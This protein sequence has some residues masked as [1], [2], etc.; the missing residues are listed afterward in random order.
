MKIE[1]TLL[2][3]SL[4]IQSVLAIGQVPFIRNHELPAQWGE[5]KVDFIHQSPRGY[6]WLAGERGVLRFNGLTYEV[7]ETEKVVGSVRPSAILESS[8]QELWIGFEDGKL[9]ILTEEDSLVLWE[10]EEGWPQ[11]SISDLSEDRH[12]N[13]WIATN[14]E[15]LYAWD[16]K[17]LSNFDE[18][19]G[20]GS[21]EVAKLTLDRSNRV[22]AATDAG[23]SICWFEGKRKKVQQLG[24]THGLPDEIIVA[25]KCDSSGMCVAATYETGIVQI[26][27]KTLEV[28]PLSPEWHGGII[29]ALE[30][31]SP[32]QVA[33]GTDNRG[34]WRYD[35]SRSSLRPL[36]SDQLDGEKV[37]GLLQDE[38]GV[39]WILSKRSG[40]HSI[41]RHFEY[42][43]FGVDNIQALVGREQLWIGTREGLYRWMPDSTG[44]GS[45]QQVITDNILSLYE[46]ALGRIWAGGFGNGLYVINPTTLNYTHLDEATGLP[47]GSIISIDGDTSSVWVATLGGVVQFDL[48]T[49]PSGNP[50]PLQSLNHESGLETNFVYKVFVDSRGM[51]WLGTDGKGI[52]SWQ[53]GKW[54]RYQEAAGHSVKTVY[55]ITEDHY[56]NIWFNTKEHGIFKYDGQAFSYLG[57]EEGVKNHSI[58]GIATDNFGNILIFH[59]GG[60][61]HF[62]PISHHFIYFGKEVGVDKIDPS[63]NSYCKDK[64]GRHWIGTGKGAI[65]YTPLTDQTSI[66]PI[67][68]IEGIRA[69]LEPL[70]PKDFSS[71]PYH[72]NDLVFDYV[73]LWYSNPGA[74]TYKYKLEGYNKDWVYSRDQQ[75]TYPNVPPGTYT[76][77]VS[78]TEN[79]AFQDEPILSYAFEIRA[80][81]W[82][83]G[84]FLI[85]AALMILSL[86]YLLMKLRDRRIQREATLVKE[87]LVSQFETL[88]SQINPHFLFNTL[89]TLITV[90]DEDQQVA[91]EYV[92]KLADFYRSIL[93]YR[94]LELIPIDEELKIMKDY[95][96]I[97][98]KRFGEN[99]VVAIEEIDQGA[100]II[101]LTLQIL[102]E[103][104]VKHNVISMNQPLKIDI[105]QEEESYIC[106]RN[107]LQ[108]KL[109]PEPS[110]GFGLESICRRYDV[111]SQKKVKIQE[112][113][114]YFK[115]SIPILNH[116]PS[117]YEN[118]DYRR[119]S[120]FFTQAREVTARSS[121]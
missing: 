73:G 108:R 38:S 43:D 20:L 85:I 69:N 56:G 77:E 62:D 107:K 28:T 23:I 47:N 10:P 35:I 120:S 33:V 2:A 106:V 63:L 68:R 111:L 41:N 71:L 57:Y 42:I 1:S 49:T 98:K 17:R 74:V 37:Q 96:Y 45:M 6:V 11:V 109:N 31:I 55:G 12:G 93:S 50:K 66:H 30:L 100:N 36:F 21:L 54:R 18:E 101:P 44:E 53:E 39:V 118:L 113:E 16:G 48:G 115:V 84:W 7:Y 8:Q 19:D 9:A 40:L 15:G 51:V 79:G 29:T 13:I 81:F 32:D 114:H 104:A 4:I 76:F 52:V 102:V 99:L 94:E 105:F 46:D 121:T 5:T 14:G 60:I 64:W 75:A 65:V 26:D 22:W 119:R 3:I 86:A 117:K 110:T 112:A 78:S 89:S 34:V 97:L 88:K 116:K 61:D 25:V 91:I 92:E 72:Q 90:I 103:N 27:S 80:P 82:K 83:R 95:I 67:T 24:R 58:S 70:E 59:P 87:K